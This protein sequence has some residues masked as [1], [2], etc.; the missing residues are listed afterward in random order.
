MAIAQ[1]GVVDVV[2]IALKD[3]RIIL[4]NLRFD[5]TLFTLVHE[6]DVTCLSFRNGMLQ[7]SRGLMLTFISTP[8]S[9]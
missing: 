4:H 8:L 5:K 6:G 9:L 7:S 1:S 3:S 2:A